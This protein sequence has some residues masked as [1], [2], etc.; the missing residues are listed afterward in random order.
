MASNKAESG[1]QLTIPASDARGCR[2]PG[3]ATMGAMRTPPKPW[4]PRVTGVLATLLI[5]SAAACAKSAKRPEVREDPA[6]PGL[7]VRSA[8]FEYRA[9]IPALHTCDGDDLTPPLS[10]SAGPDGTASY[11]LIMDDPDA[12]DGTWVHWVAW[13]LTGTSL[14]GG[15]AADAVGE[16]A[17]LQGTNSWGR[18][19]YV[20]PCPP[21]G[22]HRYFFK[23]YA[24]DTNLDLPEST[25][26]IGLLEAI[27][28]RVLAA[29]GLLGLYARP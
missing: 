3:E 16:G 5:A 9:S 17:P 23:L 19:G 7:E 11:A 28:G 2:A 10:W 27:Q 12:P 4:A 22:T 26:K 15:L 13:N 18:V 25:D 21:T 6:L 29:G 8:A 1:Q 14:A 24:L 20:G